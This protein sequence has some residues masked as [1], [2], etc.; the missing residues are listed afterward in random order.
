M[1]LADRNIGSRTVFF[2]DVLH[3]V[4]YGMVTTY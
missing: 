3:Q 1:D 2:M 4:H